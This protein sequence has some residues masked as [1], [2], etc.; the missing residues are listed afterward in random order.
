MTSL[1]IY[2]SSTNTIGALF[3]T[4]DVKYSTTKYCLLLFS[5]FFRWANI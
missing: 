3:T 2:N 5:C 1:F 4:F